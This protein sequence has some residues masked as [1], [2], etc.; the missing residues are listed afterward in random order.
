MVATRGRAWPRVGPRLTL[1]EVEARFDRMSAASPPDWHTPGQA[2]PDAPPP[3]RTLPGQRLARGV[4]RHLRG[5]DFACLFEFVPTPG[6][7]VDV[8][9]LG[10]RG[11]LWVVEC[12]SSRVD[13]VSDRKWAGYLE[14]C[15]RFFFAVDMDFPDEIL[16]E[17]AGLI[18]AD[19]FDAE[20]QRWPEPRPLAAARRR[21]LVQRFA[22]VAAGRLG[23]LIDPG[24]AGSPFRADLA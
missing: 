5:L 22:R 3:E 1:G 20:V 16:P 18:L 8:M 9:A 15:D 10:P 12:K 2:P 4:Q 19:A 6:L 14:W 13:F 21:A 17:G 11:E 23:A 7:R 24:P